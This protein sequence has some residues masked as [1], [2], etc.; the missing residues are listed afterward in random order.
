M[1]WWSCSPTSRQRWTKRVWPRGRE[2]V[3]HLVRI[4]RELPELPAE[5]PRLYV[6]TR[7]AQAV[8][9]DDQV[10]LDQAG[11]RGLLRVIGAEHPQLRPTQ[12][13]VDDDSDPE[14][15]ARELLS[16]SEE[17]ETAWRGGQWYI[18]RLSA[19]P[20]RPHE[21]RTTTV[22]HDSDGMRLEIRTPG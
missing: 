12:I 21:R 15:M 3:R 11:L 22:N 10:N 14:Q 17:D 2:H 20:L 6:V 13:D 18:A 1:A 7:A 9:P 16:G 19:T 5:P 4:A 8:L